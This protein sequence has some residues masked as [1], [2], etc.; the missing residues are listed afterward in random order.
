M[1]ELEMNSQDQQVM[2]MVNQAAAAG[3]RRVGYIISEADALRLIA[4]AREADI[5]RKQLEAMPWKKKALR[6]LGCAGRAGMCA[7]F[8]AGT[9][10]G[11]MD[12]VFAAVLSAGCAVWAAVWYRWGGCH[13]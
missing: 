2:A 10:E 4:Y 6:I 13:G 9:A 3:P 1:S 5:A 12:P 8:L 7:V 11:L